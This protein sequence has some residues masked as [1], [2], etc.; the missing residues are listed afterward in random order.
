VDL[1]THY[2]TC[3]RGQVH[4]PQASY[5]PLHQSLRFANT[6]GHVLLLAHAQFHFRNGV[7][8]TIAIADSRII[9]QYL[10][11]RYYRSAL[12]F[13]HPRLDELTQS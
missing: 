7:K 8:V 10:N 11:Y 1:L 3:A 2:Q 4:T 5:H 9:S 12:G 13:L 6:R